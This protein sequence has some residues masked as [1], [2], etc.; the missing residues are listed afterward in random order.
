MSNGPEINPSVAEQLSALV[1]GELETSGVA[2]ACANW[3]DMEL[4]RS[5]WHSYQLIGDVLR[6]EDLATS[7]GKDAS[8]LAVLRTRLA[9]EPVVLAPEPLAVAADSMPA[10][11]ADANRLRAGVLAAEPRN[12]RWSWMA[13]SAVAA[14]FVAVAGIM[15]FTQAP[16]TG[17]DPTI[18]LASNRQTAVGLLPTGV[19]TLAAPGSFIEPQE[20]V[21][22]GQL[23]RD[24]RLDR[25]LAAHKQFAG[26]SVLGVPSGFLRSASAEA[27]KH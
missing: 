17:A 6:S 20:L 27:P 24:A 16:T 25:Y 19:P 7:V 15:M 22:D 10:W 2:A 21:A 5:R 12:R 9:A 4:A 14:G 11:P 3:R 26:S 13:P 8:F 23:I 18:K 1:D